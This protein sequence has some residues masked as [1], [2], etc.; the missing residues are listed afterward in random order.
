[1]AC[2]A[3]GKGLP[4]ISYTGVGQLTLNRFQSEPEAEIG[5]PLVSYSSCPRAFVGGVM[6]ACAMRFRTSRTAGA[7]ALRPV[8]LHKSCALSNGSEDLVWA[9]SHPAAR[10]ADPDL[11]RSSSW[12]PTAALPVAELDPGYAVPQRRMPGPGVANPAAG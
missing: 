4:L 6:A 7:L 1:M 9:P 2:L 10:L 12:N 3:F 5:S 11:S 8:V